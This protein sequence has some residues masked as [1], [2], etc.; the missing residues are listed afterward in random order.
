MRINT[1]NVLHR[2]FRTRSFDKYHK[3]IRLF[4]DQSKF[5]HY[6]FSKICLRLYNFATNKIWT[7]QQARNLGMLMGAGT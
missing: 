6:A 7:I 5:G 3:E 4:S 2:A 1:K